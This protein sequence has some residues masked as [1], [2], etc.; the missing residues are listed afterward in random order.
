MGPDKT[1]SFTE[2]SRIVAQSRYNN[3]GDGVTNNVQILTV[4]AVPDGDEYDKTLHWD[5]LC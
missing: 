1:K 4:R 5:T 3:L 2:R